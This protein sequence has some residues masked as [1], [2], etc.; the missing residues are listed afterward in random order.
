[1]VNLI[2][3][4]EIEGR[5]FFVDADLNRNKSN[6]TPSKTAK[7]NSFQNPL[8]G[9]LRPSKSKSKIFRI[10]E[11]IIQFFLKFFTVRY[12][13]L[14]REK[15]VSVIRT[16]GSHP[17]NPEGLTFNQ[18]WH[19]YRR[20]LNS[21][22]KF[23]TT[24]ND[25]IAQLERHENQINKF[26]S[27]TEETKYQDKNPKRIKLIKQKKQF[28]EQTLKDV[29]QLEKDKTALFT[30]QRRAHNDLSTDGNLFLS[31]TKSS[32][33]LYT[34]RFVGLGSIMQA[35]AKDGKTIPLA[36]KEKVM[37]EL[38]FE[39]VTK[40][41]L[42][43]GDWL[44]KL[45]KDWSEAKDITTDSII[46][47]TQ[48]L[49]EK[50][51][52]VESISDITSCSDRVDTLFWRVLDV[53]TPTS[54]QLNHIEKK[55][56][57]LRANLLTLFDFFQE[58]RYTLQPH[59]SEFRTLSQL[60]EGVS[61]ELHIA[62]QKS[63]LSL[64]EIKATNRELKIIEKALQKAKKVPLSIPPKISATH[65]S[66]K[67]NKAAQKAVK[68]MTPAIW[69]NEKWSSAKHG[70]LPREV[71]IQI[72]SLTSLPPLLYNKVKTT[73][74]FLEIFRKMGDTV[75]KHPQYSAEREIAIRDIFRL[76]NEIPYDIFNDNDQPKKNCFWWKLSKNEL[77]EVMEKI[78][79]YTK[80]FMDQLEDSELIY[81]Y[82]YE[83][84]FNLTRVVSFLTARLTGAWVSNWDSGNFT[85][86]HSYLRTPARTQPNGLVKR[87]FVSKYHLETGMEKAFEK[88][89]GTYWSDDNRYVLYT[90][91]DKEKSFD[92]PEEKFKWTRIQSELIKIIN[93]D[94][95][96][97]RTKES[98]D[99]GWCAENQFVFGASLK[100]WLRPI[101]D[102]YLKA[103][104]HFV[105][106]DIFTNDTY[107]DSNSR[108]KCPEAYQKE[109]ENIFETFIEQALISEKQWDP[110]STSFNSKD[111]LNVLDNTTN[112]IFTNDEK[113]RLLHLLRHER[114]QVEL[115][116]F[117]RECPH[118]MRNPDIRNFFDSLF[119]GVSGFNNL[120]ELF[121][122]DIINGVNLYPDYFREQLEIS[123]QSLDSPIAEALT[124]K[125]LRLFRERI[126][127]KIFY[128]EF[129]EKLRNFYSNENHPTDEFID[130]TNILSD[131]KKLCEKNGAAHECLTYIARVELKILLNT[132]PLKLDQIFKNFAIIKGRSCNP[133]NLDPYFEHELDRSWQEI[134]KHCEKDQPNLQ[135]FLDQLCY[136][137]DI[138]VDGSDWKKI[139][140]KEN[141][142]IYQNALYQVNLKTC[143]VSK[144]NSKTSV[145]FLP[146]EIVSDP[147]FKLVMGQDLYWQSQFQNCEGKKIYFLK[148]K[149][150]RSVQIE[151]TN[152]KQ[153]SIYKNFTIDDS[154][155]WLQSLPKSTLFNLSTS[156]KE[157]LANATLPYFNY[158]IYQDPQD[159][160]SLYCLDKKGEIAIKIHLK[161]W[162]DQFIFK[163]ITDFRTKEPTSYDNM[164]TAHQLKSEAI[165]QLSLFENRGKII[166][167]EKRK[168][169][170]KIEL[171]RFGLS[172]SQKNGRF[173][174]NQPNYKDY[175]IDFSA[176]LQEKKGMIHSLL[177]VHPDPT[178]PKKLLFPDAKAIKDTF[179][180][181]TP[182]AYGLVKAFHFIKKMYEV[183]FQGKMPEVKQKWLKEIDPSQ[184]FLSYHCVEIRPF[185]G[186]VCSKDKLSTKEIFELTEQALAINQPSFAQ[187]MI[188]F[189]EITPTKL[190]SKGLNDLL[191]FIQKKS[192]GNGV[193]A[194]IIIKLCLKIINCLQVQK[195][196][197]E[198]LKKFFLTTL[199]SLGK[200]FFQHGRKIPK[201][202]RLSRDELT[203]LSLTLSESDQKYYDQNIEIFFLEIGTKF[204]PSNLELAKNKISTLHSRMAV[205]QNN[206]AA[207][208]LEERIQHL[209][210]SIEPKRKLLKSE[211]SIKLP[212]LKKNER[213][214]LIGISSKDIET[215][216]KEEKVR[217]PKLKFEINDKRSSCEKEALKEAQKNVDD[218]RKSEFKRPIHI[219]KGNIKGLK[220]FVNSKMIPQQLNYEKK[221]V[222]QRSRI[223]EMVRHS[224]SA[225]EQ[226]AIYSGQMTIASMDEL[227]D[228]VI[229]NNLQALQDKQKLPSTLDI[230]KLK[231]E[232]ISFFD[233]LS[234]RNAAVAALKLANQ[235]IATGKEENRE[236]WK[237]LSE[238]LYRFLTIERQYDIHQEPRLLIFEAQQFINFKPLDG[239]LD[240][241]QLLD[242]LVKNPKAIVQAPTAAG[243]TSVLSVMRALLK[244][245][246]TNL[247]IQKVLPS[248]YQQTHDRLKNVLGDLFGT[249]IYSLRFNLK[250]PLT[251]KEGDQKKDTDIPHSIFKRMYNDLL[252]TITKKGCVLTDY[253]SIPLL[254]QMFFK[255]GDKLTQ[256]VDVD[257][258]PVTLEHFTYLRKILILISNKAEEN[259][260]EFDQPNRPIQKIQLDLGTGFDTI[261]ESLIEHCM[262]IYKEV[263]K[264]KTLGLL[265]NIQGDLHETTRTKAITKITKKLAKKIHIDSGRVLDRKKLFK[266]LSGDSEDLLNDLD[267]IPLELKDK[268]AI[269]KDQLSIYLPLTLSYK[270]GSRYA[271]SENGMKVIPCY[272]GEKHDAKFGT[273]LEQINYTIQDYLQTG[274]TLADL[275]PW[276]IEQKNLWDES[277]EGEPKDNILNNFHLTLPNIS[278][279]EASQMLDSSEGIKTLLQL[280]NQDPTRIEFF[281]KRHLSKLKT[282]GKIV[283]MDPLNIVNM[284]R[285][286]SGISATMGAPESLHPN[287]QVDAHMNGQI[288]ASM[289]YRLHH[290]AAQTKVIAY[291]PS[292][293]TEILEKTDGTMVHAII[294]GAGAF[295]DTHQIAKDLKNASKKVLTQVRFHN[296]DDTISSVGK[297][298]GDLSR[299][300]FVFSLSRTRGTDEQLD[301]TAKAIL[302]LNAKDGIREVFQKEG[303]LRQPLQKCF[304]AIPKDQQIH[305]LEG[306]LSHAI[307]QD[308]LIDAQD[309]YRKSKQE[310]YA[311]LREGKKQKLLACETIEEF[312]EL[313]KLDT[314]KNS[315]INKAEA[316]Y[317]SAGS[318]FEANNKI[319]KVNAKPL[320]ALVGLRD[321]LLDEA[322]ELGL[323]KT[324]KVLKA[325]EYS[326]ALLA[327][328]PEQVAPLGAAQGELENELQ[329]EQEEETE[330]ETEFE[331]ETQQELEKNRLDQKAMAAYPPRL[332]SKKVRR[333]SK[334]IKSAY[335]EKI[336]VTD[337]FLPYSRDPNPFKRTAFDQQM[338]RVGQVYF[339]IEIE[340]GKFDMSTMRFKKTLEIKRAKIEDP[341][342]DFS[343]GSKIC[344][345]IRTNSFIQGSWQLPSD[346]ISLETVK[347]LP[348][349]IDI[350]A[351]IKFFDGRKDGYLE[352]EKES[353]K[354]WLSKNKEMKD[355]FVN[356]ILRHRSDKDLR[357]S[358]IEEIFQN[359]EEYVVT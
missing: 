94:Q 275:R 253:K 345:D 50:K 280:V 39:G 205:I 279:L 190:T 315:F 285:A 213:S 28:L 8:F 212:F 84:I 55:Q 113:R 244:S 316:S 53:C 89:H 356:D 272:N 203:F 16:G 57:K 151:S 336:Y 123:I 12:P 49:A 259:M 111:S 266:Y 216:F 153:L 293:P 219:L 176:T 102:P 199:P 115:I 314:Y 48:H 18:L 327:K 19:H 67:E 227:R 37:R 240:Q 82:E 108:I 52:E 354:M 182:K 232:L 300:G 165:D 249:S 168:V 66:L 337:N 223:E 90:K 231:E 200:D 257:K 310:L 44:K 322:R 270:G 245:N 306:E 341:L 64:E 11:S 267:D 321:R 138:L 133:K 347:N 265:K 105:V 201:E 268:I 276:I 155:K 134:V 143:E 156:D 63:Y 198:D 301:P 304:Y 344:Y 359:A 29:L 110:T 41:D 60:F 349:F 85:Y 183:Y 20:F 214:S 125:D 54:K 235:M 273:L 311:I 109:P 40:N 234:K 286:V 323:T 69:T 159:Q 164:S 215:L 180:N 148:D 4:D 91:N 15:L 42:S 163:N 72:P 128:I 144:I 71:P 119:F 278:F 246:G 161:K 162:R 282:S 288:K 58:I 27:Q 22:Q 317:Q 335:H 220:K 99:S 103:L 186:E 80:I 241:I 104:Q 358:E 194:A 135:S 325:V 96:K 258:D 33:N 157:A 31:I 308:A 5:P 172:F 10:F 6:K 62:Q 328:M 262:D 142:I 1:M 114:P 292:N 93:L 173:V 239:G 218:Y 346:D 146:T 251:Y 65:I 86:F 78:N 269:Y 149:A 97:K 191:K 147:H 77:I 357:G 35:L 290:R 309:I 318:Y 131:L 21:D 13:N 353:L 202:V 339:D 167:F 3:K 23:H 254:E 73:D 106:T 333:I 79:E 175:A 127:T 242:A 331:I 24:T 30:L 95:R 256:N 152:G 122:K 224:D 236:E 150:G 348:E 294:D 225:T 174:C 160:S 313:F 32:K 141:Q 70:V 211:L 158:G 76:F 260:D 210:K 206:L 120:K 255:F 74:Q 36:G 124:K 319:R 350:I 332:K 217:L 118:L 247:N 305:T 340:S 222:E 243:K 17:G 230:E 136:E 221:V 298:T 287:F 289:L 229:Q 320:E 296:E 68:K 329:I 171:P 121:K 126:E 189:I 179:D 237:A 195:K 132:V 46:S 51:K 352:S 61:T 59:T 130:K 271:R 284:S 187:E 112:N 295:Q 281:I 145:K 188:N 326:E 248:L 43:E 204:D 193:E 38:H 116:A 83:A 192:N 263:V 303:R 75:S 7:L 355:H 87:S 209:E 92:K 81:E 117:M 34:V 98:S 343:N 184:P 277:R 196:L 170:K 233:A 228:A 154:P 2:K 169:L 291:D 45:L 307:A 207:I 129:Y 274:I 26:K 351:Q 238:A 334:R 177:L 330:F 324:V 208:M 302:T 342:M 101:S 47:S 166:L 14:M 185:T 56:L 140:N 250:M 312:V 178:K 261:S 197:D 25:T 181:V 299:S 338:Y 283:S 252:E 137:K 100:N 9:R 226:L 297:E 107:G 139:K 88:L 264:D